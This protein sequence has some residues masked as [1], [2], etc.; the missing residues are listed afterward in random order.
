MICKAAAIVGNSRATARMIVKEGIL[1]P[2][3]AE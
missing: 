3:P 1:A 2:A